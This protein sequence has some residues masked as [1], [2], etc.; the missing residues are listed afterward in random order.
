MP[1]SSAFERNIIRQ[2]IVKIFFKNIIDKQAV[3]WYDINKKNVNVHIYYDFFAG[4]R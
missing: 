1:F 4:Y 3:S 2:Q